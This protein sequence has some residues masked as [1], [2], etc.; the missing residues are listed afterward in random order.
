[1]KKSNKKVY[2]AENGLPFIPCRLSTGKK[3]FLEYYAYEHSSGELKRKRIY[4]NHAYNSRKENLNE[5]RRIQ[6]EVDT[7]LKKG[8]ALDEPIQKVGTKLSI[9]EALRQAT[10][11]RMASSGARNKEHYQ[12]YL[13]VFGEFLELRQI[14][15]L[16]VEKFSQGHCIDLFTWLMEE[17]GVAA[18]TRN[19]YQTYLNALM[20]VLMDKEIITKNP[21]GKIKKLRA[22]S[23][24]HTTYRDE[25][26][27]TLEKYLKKNHHNLYVFTRFVYY[28]FLRPVEVC[29]LQ[30]QDIDLKRGI[31]TVYGDNSKNK[32]GGIAVINPAFKKILTKLNL[33]QYPGNYYVF[34][35]Y[36]ADFQAG[37]KMKLRK[38]F[39]EYH[40]KF[41]KELGIYDGHYTLYSWKHTG[42]KEAYDAG[43]DV[44]SIMKQNRHH[45]LEQTQTYLRGLGCIISKDLKE[46]NW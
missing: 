12:S 44:Y 7:L 45:S 46:T 43:V 25:V 17:R 11:I 30:V 5:L 23:G 10:K 34:G 29:R 8:F 39:T 14:K 41:L 28:G 6:L 36:K 4:V 40:T 21:L 38:G 32:R 1:M 31:I 9:W 15:S 26:K 13:R 3:L 24:R 22:T 19:N 42:N 2:T 16:P 27:S 35:T 37:A 18:I 20:T 33:D